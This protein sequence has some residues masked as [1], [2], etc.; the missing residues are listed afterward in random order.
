MGH[1]YPIVLFVLRTECYTV[2]YSGKAV[3]HWVHVR[4]FPLI[5][6]LNNLI[7]DESD[8]VLQLAYLLQEITERITAESFRPYEIEVLDE[9]ILEYLDTRS[10]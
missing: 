10:K 8:E 9:L 2:L 4:N 7:H 5:L 6:Y 1:L 3:S